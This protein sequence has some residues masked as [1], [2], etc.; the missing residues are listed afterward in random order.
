MASA[1]PQAPPPIVEQK[2][3]REQNDSSV[4]AH[5]AGRTNP[6]RA[7]HAVGLLPSPPPLYCYITSSDLFTQHQYQRQHQQQLWVQH[8]RGEEDAPLH[9]LDDERGYSGGHGDQQVRGR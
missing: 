2:G 9:F 4:S 5:A 3:E 6:I 1:E 7:W 8:K